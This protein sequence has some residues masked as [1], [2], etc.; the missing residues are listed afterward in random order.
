MRNQEMIEK[1]Q[2]IVK[3]EELVYFIEN[4]Y[5]KAVESLDVIRDKVVYEEN[6]PVARDDKHEYAVV[7]ESKY[8]N[9]PSKKSEEMLYKEYTNS[10]RNRRYFGIDASDF[11]KFF[12]VSALVLFV[13]FGSAVAS[14]QK[15]IWI[16]IA[17]ALIIAVIL[18]VGLYCIDNNKKRNA[19]KN[20]YVGLKEYKLRYESEY[21]KQCKRVDA[22]NAEIREDYLKSLE[23][24]QHEADL[25]NEKTALVRAAVQGE[26]QHLQVKLEDVKA[27]RD[28]LYE[29]LFVPKRMRGLVAA[30][31]ILS[32]LETGFEL[33]GS[34]GAYDQYLMDL[35]A[36]R[37]TDSLADVEQAI[38]QGTKAV[39]D[40]MGGLCTQIEQMNGRIESFAD[41]VA[42]DIRRLTSEVGAMSLHAQT[43]NEN[44]N[45]MAGSISEM[46]S[47][48]TT[49]MDKMVEYG[50]DS[51][52]ALG[53]LKSI[54]QA[55]QWNQYIAEQEMGISR[56][57]RP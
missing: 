40:V 7:R 10:T 48:M 25:Y 16:A 6:K 14:I 12:V 31:S 5:G 43:M 47:N 9:W 8:A 18:T 51:I 45:R 24:V 55:M 30:H 37:I 22:V 17:G 26:I 46:S 52:A 28:N 42:S 29:M 35:R 2:N 57:K 39:V 56:A 44:I 1:F 49:H 38:R 4:S 21:E 20:F 13:L 36:Q 23:K 3:A 33:E 32:Y 53:E 19:D 27:A 34:G 41:N 15:S 54:N 11:L 50:Q